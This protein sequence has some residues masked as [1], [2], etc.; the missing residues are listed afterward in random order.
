MVEFTGKVR[1][2]VVGI[3]GLVALFSS[4]A[5][6]SPEAP[7]SQ[8]VADAEPPSDVSSPTRLSP[9]ALAFEAKFNDLT[10]RSRTAAETVGD[11]RALRDEWVAMEALSSEVGDAEQITTAAGKLAEIDFSVGD[12]DSALAHTE[13]SITA[14][15]TIIA[16]RPQDVA[17]TYI[18]MTAMRGVILSQL[19]QADEA[20]TSQREALADLDTILKKDRFT[21]RP[22]TSEA[23]KQHALEDVFMA[24]SNLEFG[25]SQALMRNGDFETAIVLQ[26]QSLA[27]RTAGL[28]A[29]HPGIV[30]SQY[31]LAQT[32]MKAG[33]MDAA[34][35]EARG[36]VERADL[37]MSDSSTMYPKA[38][39]MLGIVL[40]R[41][42]RTSEAVRV[43]DRALRLKGETEGRDNL[44]FAYGL[45]NLGGIKRNLGDYGP[46]LNLL[47]EAE[48]G[49][50][51]HQGENSPMAATAR[52]Y[53]GSVRYA[54]GDMSGARADLENA[55]TRLSRDDDT[56]RLTSTLLADLAGT[57]PDTPQPEDDSVVSAHAR[58]VRARLDGRADAPILLDR[59]MRSQTLL[60]AGR[61][62]FPHRLAAEEA[63]RSA[64]AAGDDL[65]LLEAASLLLNTEASVAATR[66]QMRKLDGVD[67]EVVLQ[68]QSLQRQMRRLDSSRLAAIA[69]GKPSQDMSE[70]LQDVEVQL[71]SLRTK[72][73]LDDERTTVAGFSSFQSVRDGLKDDEAV[74]AMI[75]ALSRHFTLVIDRAGE[76]LFEHDQPR[77]EIAEAVTAARAAILSEDGASRDAA[78]RRAGQALLPDTVLARLEGRSRLRIVSSGAPSTVPLAALKLADDGWVGDRFALR[79]QASLAGSTPTSTNIPRGAMTRFIGVAPPEGLDADGDAGRIL[80]YRDNVQLGLPNAKTELETIA[81]RFKRADVLSGGRAVEARLKG[82]ALSSADVLAFATHGL[83]AGERGDGTQA[84][85]LVEAGLNEDGYLETDEIA[86][87]NLSARLVIL[88]ACDTAAPGDGSG[89]GYSGLAAGFLEAGAQ[90]LLVSHWPV[91][92]DAAAAITTRLVELSQDHDMDVALQTAMAEVRAGNLPGAGN[93]AIWAPFVLYTP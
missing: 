30:G 78:L 63:L 93:P 92:D 62:D 6:S 60:D 19:G 29:E 11:A 12:L 50:T 80:A 32:L 43:L 81:S 72:H 58:A 68:M 83:R 61:L 55:R 54:L 77:A 5:P 65:A 41:S 57:V 44:Y 34:L 14:A 67:A 2:R 46:A 31:G 35:Q 79:H 17:A 82:G 27:T 84:A 76:A 56:M 4:C 75:P 85:L 90:G 40:S 47:E 73:G 59:L 8:T 18:S 23:Y 70:A 37:Y 16:T 48:V 7:N 42:G 20:I 91:R 86:A 25:L 22:G 52:A 15:K 9:E 36:A 64:Q 10:A 1:L 49:F 89:N 66:A 71:A 45:H 53:R 88:S 28:P 13:R 33:D 51:T 26:R 3:I 24:K 69:A 38:L 39:E 21:F 87:L 74:V